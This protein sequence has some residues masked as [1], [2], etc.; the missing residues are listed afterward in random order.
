M[1]STRSTKRKLS[2]MLD[3]PEVVLRKNK[4]MRRTTNT[5]KKPVKTKTIKITPNKFIYFFKNN[6]EIFR[7][8]FYLF[9]NF[10]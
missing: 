3:N 7:Q 4:T 10:N 1:P 8:I 6:P 9:S 5:V 2:E